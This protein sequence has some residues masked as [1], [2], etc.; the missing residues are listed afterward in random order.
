[1]VNK[2]TLFAAALALALPAFADNP[3]TSTPPMTNPKGKPKGWIE[4]NSFSI[5]A[6]NPA[7]GSKGNGT[8]AGKTPIGDISVKN[9]CN[10]P[11]PPHSCK[12]AKPP[13]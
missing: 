9:P 12:Q 4:Q 1:M 6:T 13:H 8:A 11:N 3:S 2:A 10:K 7:G 5:G